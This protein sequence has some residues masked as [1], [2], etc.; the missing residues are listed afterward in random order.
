MQLILEK[1]Q[2]A[3]KN[4]VYF[5]V[6]GWNILKISFVQM[7]SIDEKGVLKSPLSISWDYSV[8]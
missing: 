1:L 4:T 7:V 3:A 8:V 6:F 5:L 2:W